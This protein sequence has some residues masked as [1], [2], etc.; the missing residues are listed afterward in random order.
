M[1]GPNRRFVQTI[2][3]NTTSCAE[4]FEQPDVHTPLHTSCIPRDG[5]QT[6][7]KLTI[8]I[9]NGDEGRCSRRLRLR[10]LCCR[11]LLA[12]RVRRGGA[13]TKG[14]RQQ[15]GGGQGHETEGA[16][17]GERRLHWMAL[18]RAGPHL[19]YQETARGPGI[20]DFPQG[21]RSRQVASARDAR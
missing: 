14:G 12:R 20:F 21:R 1:R 16:D 17:S 2:S 7:S 9:R 5:V 10:G 11:G 3:D 4:D 15:Y 13:A 6:T 8:A 18:Q 19:D